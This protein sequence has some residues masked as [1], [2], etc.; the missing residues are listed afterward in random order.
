MKIISSNE[1]NS[2]GL[3]INELKNEA[4]LKWNF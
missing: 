4:F 3:L 2:I 1:N